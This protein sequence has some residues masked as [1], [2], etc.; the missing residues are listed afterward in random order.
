MIGPIMPI[1]LYS[2][3][4][5]REVRGIVAYLRTLKPVRNEVPESVYRFPLPPAYVTPVTPVPEVLPDE[6]PAYGAPTDAPLTPRTVKSLAQRKWSFT[7]LSPG[8]S[9]SH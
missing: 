1:A 4:S 9:R 5:D 6:Q 8:M 2:S 7:R 3:M